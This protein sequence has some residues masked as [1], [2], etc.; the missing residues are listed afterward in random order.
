MKITFTRKEVAS[1]SKVVEAVNSNSKVAELITKRDACKVDP[2]I[3]NGT[4]PERKE[5]FGGVFAIER[6]EDEISFTMREDLSVVVLDYIAE[7][8]D[9]ITEATMAI[10]PVV[11]LFA[12]RFIIGQE[13]YIN[14]ITTVLG[15]E[16]AESED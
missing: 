3:I 9:L 8:V 15:E 6:T 13:K 5:Y 4:G 12:G 11:K 1:V 16:K 7:V 14:T 2:S 10:V